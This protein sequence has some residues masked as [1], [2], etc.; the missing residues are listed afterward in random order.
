MERQEFELV[1]KGSWDDIVTFCEQ[2][3]SV[4]EERID[5]EPYQRFDDWRPK[6]EDTTHDLREKTAEEVSVAKT[7]IEEDSSGVKEEIQEA[8]QEMRKSGQEMMKKKPRKSMKEAEEA[9]NSAARGIIPP[10]IQAFRVLEESLYSNLMG[11][12]SPHYFEC[13]AFTIAIEHQV[14]DRDTYIARFIP[15]DSELLD[16]VETRLEDARKA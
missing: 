12:T 7:D 16:T 5:E 13:G 3:A 14:L 6:R 10:I 15:E 4:L 11:R 1:E 9:G 8:G 2:L